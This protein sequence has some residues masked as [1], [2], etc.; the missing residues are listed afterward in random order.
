MRIIIPNTKGV[1]EARRIVERSAEDLFRSAAGGVI[2]ISG[3]EKNCHGDVAA[4]FGP[5]HNHARICVGSVGTSLTIAAI[6]SAA[7]KTDIP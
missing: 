1:D 7:T 6:A 4:P 2:Q 5:N 3:V